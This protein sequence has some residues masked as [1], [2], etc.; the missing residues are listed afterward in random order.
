MRCT[1]LDQSSRS[2][3]SKRCTQKPRTTR[4][5]PRLA[6]T[7]RSNGLVPKNGGRSMGPSKLVST[8]A[9]NADAPLPTARAD[10]WP[11]VDLH[12]EHPGFVVLDGRLGPTT[13]WRPSSRRAS[14]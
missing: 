10:L 9:F 13:A 7:L 8:P 14:R 1:R 5:P 2:I 6:T 12:V 3:Y 11:P 4:A